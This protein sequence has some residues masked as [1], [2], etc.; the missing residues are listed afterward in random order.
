MTGFRRSALARHVR[1]ARSQRIC[2]DSLIARVAVCL[3]FATLANGESGHLAHDGE[4]DRWVFS[5]ALE[6]G[7][8]GDSGDAEFSGSPIVGPRAT[9]ISDADD[10]DTVI[11]SR[12]DSNDMISGLVGANFEVM[13]PGPRNLATHPRL[14]MNVS[15]LGALSS[16]TSVA[17]NSD[18][19]EWGI[20]DGIAPAAPFVGELI[21]RGHGTEVSTQHQGA[22]L[23]VGLG[24]AFTFDFKGERIRVKPSVVYS[25]TET[26]ISV[27]ANRAIRIVES[28]PIVNGRRVRSLDSYRLLA[29]QDDFTKVYHGVGPALEVE[30]DTKNRFGPFL[31][32]L[33]MKGGASHLFG[34]RK[35]EFAASNPDE[36]LETVSWKY[37]QDRWAYRASTGVRFRYVPKPMR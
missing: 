33:F 4:L 11:Q 18:P 28:D 1:M 5:G 37:K 24:P 16:E 27:V 10:V 34:D 8:Y 31:L 7:L 3:L 15:L 36:P 19:G 30:Y 17:R 22:Q 12:M 29:L 2:G 35:T 9:N 26:K 32:S 14:F 20:P 13:T 23:Y 21:L 6:V 25:R